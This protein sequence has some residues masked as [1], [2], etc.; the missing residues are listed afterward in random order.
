MPVQ[1][2]EY[3]NMT[4]EYLESLVTSQS[5]TYNAGIDVRTSVKGWTFQ[6]NVAPGTQRTFGFCLR[7]VSTVERGEYAVG[8][9]LSNGTFL[10]AN[11]G[12]VLVPDIC[13]CNV[14]IPIPTLAP[15]AAPSLPPSSFLYLCV[16]FL[17]F[18]FWYAVC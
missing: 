12:R 5:L 18:F 16:F 17:H 6:G 9:I 4:A 11:N 1:C 8:G 7:N 3:A 14:T 15:T 2:D 13:A 10:Y